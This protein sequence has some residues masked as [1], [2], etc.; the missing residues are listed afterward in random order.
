MVAARLT[1]VGRA[2][3]IPVL[4]PPT[5][6][7]LQVRVTRA[8]PLA[9]IQGAGPLGGVQG[10]S[11]IRANLRLARSRRGLDSRPGCHGS[12]SLLSGTW[13]AIIAAIARTVDLEATARRFK[14]CSASGRSRAPRTLLRLA[15]M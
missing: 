5:V 1:I 10:Q 4:V 12:A 7:P 8:P 9:G 2:A 3:T 14:A 15:L 6:Q 11:P 13:P